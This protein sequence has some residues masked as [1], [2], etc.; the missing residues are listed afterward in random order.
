MSYRQTIKKEGYQSTALPATPQHSAA[1]PASALYQQQPGMGTVWEDLTA[2]ELTY[3]VPPNQALTGA[4]E[5]LP[6]C[7]NDNAPSSETLRLPEDGHPQGQAA[8]DWNT[9]LKTPNV[10]DS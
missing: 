5:T 1:A 6:T 4:M 2:S 3:R 10:W 9:L 7:W 8:F